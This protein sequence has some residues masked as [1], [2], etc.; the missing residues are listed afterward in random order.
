MRYGDSSLLLYR[1]DDVIN[2]SE[3]SSFMLCHSLVFAIIQRSHHI[4]DS[5]QNEAINL[6]R[7]AGTSSGVRLKVNSPWWI[8]INTIIQTIGL[9]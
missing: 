8:S 2:V 9:L 5:K 6:C 4:D 1:I 3:N 7:L